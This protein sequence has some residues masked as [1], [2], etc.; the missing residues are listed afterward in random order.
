MQHVDILDRLTPTSLRTKLALSLALMS[1]ITVLIV[2]WLANQQL[3]QK[4]DETIRLDASKRF[5]HDVA[6]YINTYGSWQK[7][8]AH[9]T[10]RNFTERNALVMH[11]NLTASN[12]SKEI[13]ATEKGTPR[14][15]TSNLVRPAFRFYLFNSNYHSLFKLPPYAVGDKAIAAHMAELKPIYVN[16]KVAA[17]YVPEGKPSYSDLDLGYIEAVRHAIVI[18]ALVALITAL[19]LG[20]WYASYLTSTLRNLTSAV[21]AMG[22]GDLRQQVQIHSF[23]EVA[24][25]AKAFNKMSKELAAS[26]AELR[27][28][29]AQIEKQAE[30]L[31]ELSVRD[32]LTKLYNRRYFDTQGAYLFNQAVRYHR[33]FS[34]MIGDIDFFKKINDAYSHAVGDEVLRRIG[35][36]MTSKM[37][38]SD[39]VARYGGEEF[40]IAFPETNLLQAKATCEALRQ[41]IQEYPWHEIQANMKVTM[42]MGLCAET[43]VGSIH[44]MLQIADDMLYKAKNQG[45]NQVLAHRP[46]L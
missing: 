34:V 9:E 43:K 26:D 41:R 16:D 40:V 42:S 38:T 21:Q 7:G 5:S 11:Q 2:G 18:G 10:F 13:S 30:L 15:Y 44:E 1:L 22:Q 45:R 32:E 46:M 29:Y 28:S 24:L 25:L 14:P 37:R 33:P 19:V 6:A 3:M 4:F 27:E 35:E 31:R 36:I 20:F 12:Q 23:D 8:Q 17:Y 39:L